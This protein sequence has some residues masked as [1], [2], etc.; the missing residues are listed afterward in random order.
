MILWYAGCTRENRKSV[1]LF[2][3]LGNTV[4]QGI[5]MK[6]YNYQVLS[7][8]QNS[9]VPCGGGC[10]TLESGVLES[11]ERVSLLVLHLIMHPGVVFLSSPPV[12]LLYMISHTP[13]EYYSDY[14]LTQHINQ[15][16]IYRFNFR[17]SNFSSDYKF[18]PAH[19]VLELLLP[20]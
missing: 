20:L 13:T 6:R 17:K 11:G 3:N 19:K 10:W 4:L 12:T 1:Q 14:K 8:Q 5:N 9:P 16:H 15:P 18:I 7:P 2:L